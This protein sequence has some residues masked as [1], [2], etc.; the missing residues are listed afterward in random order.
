MARRAGAAGDGVLPAGDVHVERVVAQQLDLQH[1]QPCAERVTPEVMGEVRH[2]DGEV[3]D[4]SLVRRAHRRR[5]VVDVADRAEDLG[6]QAL[7]EREPGEADLEAL[8]QRQLRRSGLLLDAPRDLRLQQP[9]RLRPQREEVALQVV[10]ATGQ[11]VGRSEQV[12]ARRAQRSEER[13]RVEHR[14]VG[15]V[16]REH[17]LGVSGEHVVAEQLEREVPSAEVAQLVVAR[18]AHD[19]RRALP[20]R[21]ERHVIEAD[22]HHADVRARVDVRVDRDEHVRVDG[23]VDVE[24]HEHDEPLTARRRTARFA[25]RCRDGA[26]ELQRADAGGDLA[27]STAEQVGDPVEH[28]AVGDRLS[29]VGVRGQVALLRV[30]VE[31]SGDAHGERH[32]TPSDL[33]VS[34]GTE[35]LETRLVLADADSEAD[36]LVPGDVGLLVPQRMGEASEPLADAHQVLERVDATEVDVGMTL[37]VPGE[38]DERARREAFGATVRDEVAE[39]VER[40]VVRAT[41]MPGV[42]GRVDERAGPDAVRES[43]VEQMGEQRVAVTT[44]RRQLG[45]QEGQVD[46]GAGVAALGQSGPEEVGERIESGAEDVG[47][48]R[49]VP[50]TVEHERKEGMIGQVT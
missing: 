48:A 32:R 16:V 4:R 34:G 22:R 50:R 1:R 44:E 9:Q 3:R 36:V 23:A 6:G 12:R 15:A 27:V 43:L 30:L 13:L 47:V 35:V 24:V 11:R 2:G 39:D 19:V 41:V 33:G 25:C 29:D 49:E 21:R 5:D 37:R 38:V 14:E 46:V 28:L 20:Q 45:R 31:L 8:D 17:D 10:A 40:F 42:P 7:V 26:R 18:L